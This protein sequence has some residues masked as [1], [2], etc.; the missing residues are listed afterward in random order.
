M[1]NIYPSIVTNN[2]SI[3]TAPIK[4]NTLT[5]RNNKIIRHTHLESKFTPKI[6]TSY[7][8]YTNIYMKSYN[9]AIQ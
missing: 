4:D 3:L 5:A 1:K 8:K 6:A 2:Y 9:A 7:T